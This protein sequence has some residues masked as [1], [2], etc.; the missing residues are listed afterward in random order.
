MW[1]TVWMPNCLKHHPSGKQEIFVWTF[2]Y[3][4]KLRIVPACICSDVS[5]AHLDATQCSISYEI[6]IPIRTCSS[7]R[8]VAH[9]KF[10]R[11]DD[12]LHGRM[13]EPH[14]WKLCL[15]NQPFGRHILWS[16]RAKPWYGNC[17]QLKYGCPDDMATPSGRGSIQERIYVKFGKP[18]T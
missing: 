9:S 7:I 17:V 8:Q 11:L 15:S 13:R 14:I 4:E 10:R 1:H 18:I 12:G 3:V 6:W 16:G 5:A 2:L